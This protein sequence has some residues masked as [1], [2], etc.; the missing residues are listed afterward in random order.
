MIQDDQI[1]LNCRRS[2]AV[3]FLNRFAANS[4]AD[5]LITPET[6]FP[7]E[8]LIGVAGSAMPGTSH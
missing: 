5:V 1:I 8:M 4:Q 2:V 7:T 6:E 3:A